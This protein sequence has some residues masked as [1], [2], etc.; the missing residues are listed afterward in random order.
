VAPRRAP[1]FPE[2]VRAATAQWDRLVAAVD[3][4][5]DDAFPGP[6]RVGWTV[7]QLCAH[8]VR[9]VDAVCRALSAPAGPGP[10]ALTALDYFAA[11]RPRYRAIDVR[12]RA[13][14][15]D[16]SPGQLRGALR[17]A[18]DQA[19]ADVAGR[20]ARTAV[21][22]A[23]GSIRLGDLL[24][25]RCVEAVVHGLDLPGAA[26]VDP[27][28]DALRVSVRLLADMLAARVP[29]R[30]VEVR[31]PPHAVVSCGA[32]EPVGGSGDA[33]AQVGP[34]RGPRHTRGT[35][36]NVVEVPPGVFVELACGRMDWAGAARAGLTASGARADLSG[37]LPLL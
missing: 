26:R 36:P 11:V 10:P 35:P 2:L 37:H 4:L 5:G 23:A 31:V 9:T 27:D 32:G 21:V 16:S 17:A 12:A 33:A 28:P 14:A 15:A 13:S 1:A 6:T 30:A 8:L 19:R 22:T 7:A 20:D 18:V 24:E 34:G 3:G 25:T 29:G